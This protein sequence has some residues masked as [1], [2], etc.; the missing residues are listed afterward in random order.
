LPAL[1]ICCVIYGG[2]LQGFQQNS[3]RPPGLSRD[4][5]A[6][7]LSVLNQRG[8][9]PS[10]L[11]QTAVLQRFSHD[12]L[13]QLL[14]QA[15]R[16]L[17]AAAIA[18]MADRRDGTSRAKIIRIF[19]AGIPPEGSRPLDSGAAM[20]PNGIRF[21]AAMRYVA[22]TEGLGGA[23]KIL[24]RP[25]TWQM[26][27]EASNA[28]RVAGPGWVDAA[29]RQASDSDRRA[30]VGVMIANGA[31]ADNA[32]EVVA[33]LKEGEAS[34]WKGA[35]VAC[36]RL[37]VP[38]CW[39]TLAES[40]DSLSPIDRLKVAMAAFRKGRVTQDRLFEEAMRLAEAACGLP[41]GAELAS[42]L[43]ALLE[44]EGLARGA[45]LTVPEEIT[46]RI[47]QALDGP[48]S[49]APPGRR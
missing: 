36:E 4:E 32:A 2:L 11:S 47:R 42:S 5:Y 21:L 43:I 17:Q 20:S 35:L 39:Q 23:I 38:A 22:A 34:V 19:E 8:E 26:P 24:G 18:E 14:D 13:D 1:S 7:A 9:H 40:L 6:Q 46:R 41:R 15:N 16:L 10:L 45:G 37:D 12:Q 48:V 25:E 44:F 3:R 29:L 27:R 49:P 31:T 30:A 28:L 33:A